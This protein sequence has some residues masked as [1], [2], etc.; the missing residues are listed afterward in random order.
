MTCRC[1]ALTGRWLPAAAGACGRYGTAQQRVERRSGHGRTALLRYVAQ[2]GQPAGPQRVLGLGGADKPDW[3][4][5]DETRL[6]PPAENL[7]ERA[8]RTADHPD[9]ARAG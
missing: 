7:L 2:R 1:Q 5:D 3:Q 9:R 4:A 6:H 8:E